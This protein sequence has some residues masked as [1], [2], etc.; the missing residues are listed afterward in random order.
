MK[1]GP[2]GYIIATVLPLA[3]VVGL[4]PLPIMP[5]LLLLLTARP[6]AN[7]LAYLGAWV[8]ALTALV[9][10][11]V[12]AGSAADP[13]RATD[14]GV[15][16]I[17]VITGAA[18]L[19]LAGAKWLRRP[20][21]G[22]PKEPPKWLAALDSY[23]PGQSARLGALLAAA[24]PKNLAMSL[25]AGAEIALLAPTPGSTAAGI[26]L[27]VAVGSLGVGVP[28]LTYAAVG[29]RAAPALERGKRWLERNSTALAVGVLLVLGAVMVVRGLPGAV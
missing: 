9:G 24:N 18:F 3:L 17:Q 11:V 4:S 25:A 19:I 23:S 2:V 28:V 8:L 14:A 21:A 15:A 12:A 22:Q 1:G 16:W 20:R 10:A 5:A 26:A 27:F 6:R 29:Q 13:D 7:S